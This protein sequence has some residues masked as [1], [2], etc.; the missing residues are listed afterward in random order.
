MDE[1]LG[2][3]GHELPGLEG[4]V[5]G[6]GVPQAGRGVEQDRDVE[7]AVAVCGEPKIIFIENKIITIILKKKQK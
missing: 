5:D 4:A 1:G 7:R 6:V 2:E 3:V